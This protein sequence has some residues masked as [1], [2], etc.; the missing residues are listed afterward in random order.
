MALGAEPRRIAW[1]VLSDVTRL[2]AAGILLGIPLTY[3]ASELL[4]TMLYN[5]QSFGPLSIAVSLLALSTI[6]S[7]AAWL[8]AR[9]AARI[10]PI[11]ALRYE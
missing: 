5:V 3:A 8:P 6:A 7:L 2:T 11:I 10:D 1:M 9:R 4:K